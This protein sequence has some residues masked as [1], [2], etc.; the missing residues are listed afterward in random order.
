MKKKSAE[1]L[2]RYCRGV[3]EDARRR[4]EFLAKN[5]QEQEL[6]PMMKKFMRHDNARARGEASSPPP[7]PRASYHQPNA[8]TAGWYFFY[9]T[10]M[11]PE[12]LLE[13]SELEEVPKM[14]EGRVDL[15]RVKYWGPYPVVVES[16]KQKVTVSGVVCFI[17]TLDVVKRIRAYETDKYMETMTFV[18][19]ASG[20]SIRCRMFHWRMG[21]EDECLKDEP[22]DDY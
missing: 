2:R 4:K 16:R 5:P 11:D 12:G 15:S 9:G 7:N 22:T 3:E 18:D 6:S 19:S 8:P 14:V 1:K 10:L 21:D 17:L 13:I 20:Q